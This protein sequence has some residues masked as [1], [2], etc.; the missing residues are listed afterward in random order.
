MASL[1]VLSLLVEG[2]L[3]Y[4]QLLAHEKPMT[5]VM[6]REGL[7]DETISSK[8]VSHSAER[9]T[10]SKYKWAGRLIR[11]DVLIM[12]L[13]I[14]IEWKDDLTSICPN[15][16]ICPRSGTFSDRSTSND[17]GTRRETETRLKSVR[18]SSNYGQRSTRTPSSR[19]PSPFGTL[20]LI[21]QRTI[22]V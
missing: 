2:N 1:R 14:K 11:G 4:H 10:R 18:R 16:A 8:Y 5:G 15:Y 3:S 12:G 6:L 22:I 17:L 20:L 19:E 7:I 21:C 13:T 9:P